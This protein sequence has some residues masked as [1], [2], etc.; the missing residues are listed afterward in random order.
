LQSNTD[1]HICE[2]K[3]SVTEWCFVTAA[4]PDEAGD[5]NGKDLIPEVF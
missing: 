3:I 5:D 1:I 4:Y 2:N